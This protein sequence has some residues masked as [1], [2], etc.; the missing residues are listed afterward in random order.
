MNGSGE[1]GSRP[2][3]RDAVAAPLGW[4][5]LVEAP[6]SLFRFPLDRD[7]AAI[8]EE[9]WDRSW[10]PPMPDDV[11]I[12]G[13]VRAVLLELRQR[14]PTL[15]LL[16]LNGASV[17]SGCRFNT[18]V[19]AAS[20][21][22]RNEPSQRCLAPRDLHAAPGA[23]S[24]RMGIWCSSCARTRIFASRLRPALGPVPCHFPDRRVDPRCRIVRR[25]PSSRA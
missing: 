25:S 12:R 15:P 5:L 19:L 11:A 3:G 9:T 24:A 4:L 16:I 18:S 10:W 17:E 2:I 7:R 8:L 14:A 23:C 13:A 21:R 20:G 1:L 6:W 22:K